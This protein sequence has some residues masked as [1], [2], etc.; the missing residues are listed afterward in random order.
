MNDQTSELYLVCYRYM[1]QIFSMKNLTIKFGKWGNFQVIKTYRWQEKINAI[2]YD[3]SLDSFSIKKNVFRVLYV[4]LCTCVC[5]KFVSLY[6]L[7]FC[8]L[9]KWIS[10]HV[11]HFFSFSFVALLIHVFKNTSFYGTVLVVFLCHI[12]VVKEQCFSGK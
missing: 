1:S 12:W 4:F 9:I 3:T 10:L 11:Y 8:V 6:L 7:F 5:E 2:T